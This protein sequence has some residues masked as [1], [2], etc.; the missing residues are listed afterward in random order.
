[1]V[2]PMWSDL[3]GVEDLQLVSRQLMTLVGSLVN[4]GSSESVGGSVV[5]P[6]GGVQ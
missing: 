1:M 5:N 4:G 2:S 3:F 6:L